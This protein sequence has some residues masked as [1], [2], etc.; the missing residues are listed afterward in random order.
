[1]LSLLIL[2]SVFGIIL[3][4]LGPVLTTLGPKITDFTFSQSKL[5]QRNADCGL[6]ESIHQF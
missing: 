1:M 2:C 6:A 5:T 3:T 4:I